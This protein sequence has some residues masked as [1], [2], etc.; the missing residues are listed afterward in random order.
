MTDNEIKRRDCD[1]LIVGA[2]PVG[3]VLALPLPTSIL[4]AWRRGTAFSVLQYKQFGVLGAVAAQQHCRDRQQ[5]PGH[6]AQQ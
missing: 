2:G 3:Q 6:L 1:V 5:P 4:T